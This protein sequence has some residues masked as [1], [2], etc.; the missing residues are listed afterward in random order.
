[1]TAARL[2]LGGL[3][4]VLLWLPAGCSDAGC[5]RTSD[6]SCRMPSPCK[7]LSYTC[8]A[9]DGRGLELRTITPEG[10][11]A[12]G[13]EAAL[14][15]KGDILLGNDQVVAVIAGLGDQNYVD[16]SGGSLLDLQPRSGAADALNQVVTAVGILPRD[17]VYYT[18]MQLIDERPLRVGVQLRGTLYQQPEVPV[19]T[20]FELRPCEPGLRVRSVIENGTPDPQAW[21]LTDG[22]YWSGREPIP[23]TPGK[24]RGFIH[25]DFT[26]LTINDVFE[27]APYL[28]A[29]N[30]S[31]PTI[32]YGEVG[33][34]ETQLE[35]FQ[36]KQVSTFGVPRQVVP[37][38]GVVIFE[39]MIFTA[40]GGDVAATVD[41]A[42]EARRQ[43]FD[44][45]YVTIRGK[46]DAAPPP[47]GVLRS[48]R[49]AS[50]I[51]TEGDATT[52]QDQRSPTTQ[53]VPHGDG[54]F[55][56]RVPR[57][58]HYLIEVNAFGRKV[59][60]QALGQVSAD[61]DVG[62][63]TMPATA[64]VLVT[65]SDQMSRPL[66]AEIYVVPADDATAASSKGDLY[67]TYQVCAPWLGPQFGPS[68]ACNRFL[69]WH[70]LGKP[71]EVEVPLGRYWLYAFH[72]PFF[73]IQRQLVELTGPDAPVAFQLSDL[74]LQPQGTVSGDFHVHGA[75]SFDSAI[76]DLD[77]VLSFAA[78]NMD[79]IVATDHDVVYDYAD[80][81]KQLG[82]DGYLSTVS[83]DE[84]TGHVP[85][86]RIP[87]YGFPLV[88][89][90][91]NFWPLRF[92]PTLPRNGGP[93]DELIEP[94]ELFDRTEPLYSTNTS[95]IELNHPWAE[96]EFGRDLGFPR[97]LSLSML[98]DLP[99]F[100]DG[101][102]EGMYVRTPAGGHA[103]DSHH[104]QEVMNG[105]F[106]DALLQYR[107]FWFYMLS[108]G[109]PKTGTAN[110][111]S[112][113]LTDNT[114]GTPR[115]VVY[116]DTV[117]G[118]AFDIER[119]NQAVRQGRLFGTNGP[120]IEAAIVDAPGGGPEV[121]LPYGMAPIAPGPGARLR[122]VVSAAPWVPVDEVRV[123][124]NG[125][126]KTKVSGAEI[127]P[128][129][130]PFGSAGL[131]RLTKEIPLATL[132]DS[133]PG[134]IDA[135][136]V[137][138]AGTALP[139]AGDLGGGL[140]GEPDGIPDTTDNNGD[141]V[142][143]ARDIAAG[144]KIG[145]L[146]TPAAPAA[147]SPLYHFYQVTNGYPFAYTNPFLI[148]RNGNGSFD[149]IGV[150]NTP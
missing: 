6:P 15:R 82:L 97:A 93:F 140:H 98:V 91:Y 102:A 56:A 11:P 101:T 84:T 51:I 129:S 25:P 148:D 100:D 122:I 141:G 109:K 70:A 27:K 17:S 21:T 34:R 19:V 47:V 118:P 46:V 45:P 112:H 88:I 115:N 108:Q 145:P 113:S 59:G 22:W 150:K 43:L 65:V 57:G 94:G 107:A 68:P 138:E 10:P 105:S 48:E 79:V 18:S 116:T 85:F 124:V 12:P 53:V 110:S 73:T 111:D 31:T 29:P 99:G 126:E 50:L 80:V 39:R 2:A 69:V 135:W 61:L 33:C 83:G 36:S 71:V 103:N 92:D 44:E 41:L 123:I 24:G 132:L 121:E 137:V 62:T 76:P 95:L 90:H 54:T 28:A 5:L 64:R 32:S 30:H 3:A 125:A 131:V 139:L 87:D 52:P 60:E 55:S 63:I 89:G 96:P 13:G 142:V 143:D 4:L 86:M 7:Q 133:V 38:A 144:K 104:A 128:A 74:Q 77:R 106:N 149:R 119:F 72:G 120:I 8:D 147:G 49:E 9:L 81:A 1:L 117:K 20:L 23:F 40:S 66:D 37:P 26:L 114:I 134:G 42:L 16:I 127:S 14:P 146:A 136:I 78:T 58:R 35:G 130:D 75:A 67:G